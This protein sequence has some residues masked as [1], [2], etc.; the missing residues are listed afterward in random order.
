MIS[1]VIPKA[2]A[3]V[4]PLP[5]ARKLPA[6]SLSLL[7]ALFMS[8]ITALVSPLHAAPS[9]AC[10]GKL[11]TNERLICTSKRL[12]QLD[13]AITDNFYELTA[14]L[15]RAAANL[16]RG[17]QKRFII[18]RQQCGNNYPCTEALMQG[19]F[20]QLEGDL[21]EQQAYRNGEDPPDESAEQGEAPPDESSARAE[22]TDEQERG[23]IIEQ[24]DYVERQQLDPL[25]D[26]RQEQNEETGEDDICGP[27]FTM[28]AGKCVHNSDLEIEN[29]F[30]YRRT[31]AS[32]R[33]WIYVL[34]HGA[35]L[36]L[37]ASAD[38]L[39]FTQSRRR[40]PDAKR[41]PFFVIFQ[42]GSY[43]ITEPKS[44]LRL[45]ADGGGDRKVSVR[46]QP[47]DDFTKFQLRPA[48]EGCFHVKTVA[49]GNYWT[50]QRGTQLI[51][52]RK[53]PRGEFSIF[54]FEKI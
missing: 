7:L 16:V 44:G 52:L 31:L 13:Q 11:T 48:N 41:Q 37:D 20:K 27:G 5:L 2:L 34:A 24:R 46:Y 1:P 32:G 54:C 25:E 26:N 15:N 50:W 51:R 3:N 33:Y 39:L 47:R 38:K 22:S 10:K 29:T 17:D 40:D 18:A 12:S 28:R 21:R 45:H 36:Y 49:T 4:T 8:A 53:R 19:R 30:A 35:G 23:E 42:N 43:S 14:I 9:F 6:L